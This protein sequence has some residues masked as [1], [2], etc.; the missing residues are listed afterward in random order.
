MKIVIATFNPDKVREL[1]RLIDL[2]GV[3]LVSLR[4]FAGAKAP[5]ENGNTLLENARIKAR[6]AH[7]LTGL[8]SIADDTGLEVD[9]LDGR[10]GIYAARFAG[11]DATYA[12]N[13][14]RLLAELSGVEPARRTA[15]FRTVCAAVLEGGGELDAEGVLEGVITATPRGTNGFGYDPVFEIPVFGRT[16]AELEGAEKNAIS[17]RARSAKALAEKLRAAAGVR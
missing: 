8:T 16:L 11:P 13:V 17:H 9:A 7:A 10:P 15:R 12:D 6:A 3:T 2:P 14:Q 4:E 5:E 1:E